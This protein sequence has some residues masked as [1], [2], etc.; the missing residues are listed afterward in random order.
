MNE[1]ATHTLHPN[2]NSSREGVG[3]RRRLQ[4]AA[5]PAGLQ[6]DI[7]ELLDDPAPIHGRTTGSIARDREDLSKQMMVQP[8][9][10]TR[11]KDG[12][13][14]EVEED[15]VAAVAAAAG[16]CCCGTR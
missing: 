1:S 6:L 9:M 8:L 3:E 2:I 16:C 4:G 5:N 7:L 11:S 14:R 10:A 12:A 13:E 15:P